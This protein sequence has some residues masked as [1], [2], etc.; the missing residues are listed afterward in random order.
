[1][2]RTIEMRAK[3][4][5]S[6]PD[7]RAGLISKGFRCLVRLLNRMYV[8]AN[9]LAILAAPAVR[10]D[11]LPTEPGPVPSLTKYRCV[12]VSLVNTIFRMLP[13]GTLVPPRPDPT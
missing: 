10:R 3:C 1:M 7:V 4:K 12:D 6:P 5:V 8:L 2:R 9:V 13:L 11:A